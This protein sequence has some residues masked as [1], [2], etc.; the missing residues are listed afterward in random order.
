M[1]STSSAS[2]VSEETI[3]AS[4]TISNTTTEVSTTI[5]NVIVTTSTPTTNTISTQPTP[6]AITPCPTSSTERTLPSIKNVSEEKIR[7]NK[8]KLVS[9]IKTR[10]KRLAEK[11]MPS[12]YKLF[13]VIFCYLQL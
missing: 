6:C 11:V 8:V 12:T 4:D 13:D 5:V 7:R 10:R 3:R 1:P 2:T 9:P